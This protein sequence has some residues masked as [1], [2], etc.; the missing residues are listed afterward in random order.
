MCLDVVFI[1]VGMVWFVV[2]LDVDEVFWDVIFNVN[3]KGVFF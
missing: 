2:V 1:N 3:V